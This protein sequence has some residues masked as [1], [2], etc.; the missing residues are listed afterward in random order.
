MKN[1]QYIAGEKMHH[2]ILHRDQQTSVEHWE[3]PVVDDDVKSSP[4]LKPLTAKQ[5]EIIQKQ[6]FDEGYR[7][8]LEASKKDVAEKTEQMNQMIFGLIQPWMRVDDEVE[9]QLLIMIKAIAKAVL[10][11]EAETKSE[12]LL[13]T[14]K[15]A[16]EYL[17]VNTGH[18]KLKINPE[19]NIFLEEI[20]NKLGSDKKIWDIVLD[21]GIARGEC[22]IETEYT[23]I[24]ASFD[25]Q[26]Q[27]L[28]KD[29]IH[30]G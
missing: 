13:N 8:G 20:N 30:G 14:I 19:D 24:D 26:I 12:V 28:F 18:I 2:N 10:S 17:P 3:E 5:I 7:D 11:Y 27:N 6:A 1:E 15:R 21:T 4:Y 29:I 9:Q 22:F 23:V 25:T 16:K